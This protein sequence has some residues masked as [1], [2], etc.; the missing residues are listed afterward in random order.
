MKTIQQRQ[1]IV[2][3][4]NVK[5]WHDF[6]QHLGAK[7]F[8]AEQMSL[9]IVLIFVTLSYL[10]PPLSFEKVEITFRN[11][12]FLLLSHYF[13]LTYHAPSW[14]CLVLLIEILFE[15]LDWFCMNGN[16][17]TIC[18]F[19]LPKFGLLCCHRQHFSSIGIFNFF[20][21][22]NLIITYE[23]WLTYAAHFI[24]FF[25]IIS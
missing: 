24:S 21:L 19:L 23:L 17:T 15:V 9:L 13:K 5:S 7:I 12:K 22:W 25:I 11:G 10:F 4:E 8:A 14:T 3:Q 6:F 1:I 16:R 2:N 18:P 20:Y